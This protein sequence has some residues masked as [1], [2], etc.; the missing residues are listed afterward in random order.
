MHTTIELLDTA[1]RIHNVS[2]YKLA[3]LLGVV[4]SAVKNYRQ[5]R[6][7][8]DERVCKKIAELIGADTDYVVVCIQAERSKNDEVKSVWMSIAKRLETASPAV[9]LLILSMLG[10][11]TFTPDAHASARVAELAPAHISAVDQLYI[12]ARKTKRAFA[13]KWREFMAFFMDL[14]GV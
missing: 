5:G 13:E 8:P 4:S 3:Q 2:D 1:K 12:V 14:Q 10:G 7:H 9:F 11:L 6:S